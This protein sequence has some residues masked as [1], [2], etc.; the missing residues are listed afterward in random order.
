V[1][2]CSAG[3]DVRIFTN[4]LRAVSQLACV[5]EKGSWECEE[6]GVY[7]MCAFPSLAFS[8]LGGYF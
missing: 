7:P 3:S 8:L 5:L 1:Y 2:V 4:P 6:P